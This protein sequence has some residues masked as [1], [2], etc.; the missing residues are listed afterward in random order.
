MRIEAATVA[1][2]LDAVPDTQRP[3]VAKLLDLTR[4]NIQHGFDEVMNWGMI[5]FEVPLATSGKTYNG[6]PL[7]YISIGAQKKHVG[8]Y[9]CGLYCSPPVM[10]RFTDAYKAAGIK[11]DMGKACVRLKRM[12]QLEEAALADAIAAFTA[13]EYV[14]A[15]RRAREA[16]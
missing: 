11:L 1:E 14:E 10:E 6:K 16:D 12:D 4:A 3:I 5:T 15:T 8:F 7:M 2:Y 9:A 13:D